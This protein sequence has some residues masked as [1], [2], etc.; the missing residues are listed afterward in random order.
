MGIEEERKDQSQR[1]ERL[2]QKHKR[3]PA[4][5]G[6]EWNEYLQLKWPYFFHTGSFSEWSRTGG[7]PFIEDDIV[8]SWPYVMAV[9]GDSFYF[10]YAQ[11]DW[12]ISSGTWALQTWLYYIDYSIG[13]WDEDWFLDILA[14]F[15]SNITY[16]P[17]GN[18]IRVAS[19]GLFRDVDNSIFN[20]FALF[21][22][23]NWTT[24]YKVATDITPQTGQW[25]LIRI[26]VILHP[27]NGLV[28]LYINGELKAT[29]SGIPIGPYEGVMAGSSASTYGTSQS[30]RNLRIDNGALLH[31]ED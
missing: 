7:S 18:A 14:C 20:K 6:G 16:E 9:E 5:T 2:E 26:E 24:T 27:S 19:C 3:K 13:G 31:A 21:I 28:R 22:R 25:Y 12:V 8:Y 30:S 1:I 11:K 17:Y 23:V 15:Q 4:S 29:K 10:H